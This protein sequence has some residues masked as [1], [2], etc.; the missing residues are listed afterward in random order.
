MGLFY[1]AGR[2]GRQELIPI[3][4]TTVVVQMGYFML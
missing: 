4:E 2:S 1:L 3:G